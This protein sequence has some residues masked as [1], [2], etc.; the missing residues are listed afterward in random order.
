MS[1]MP[2]VTGGIVL[3]FSDRQSRGR[4][5]FNLVDLG[6]GPGK[7]RRGPCIWFRPAKT[8]GPPPWTSVPDPA[9][10]ERQRALPND[11]DTCPHCGACARHRNGTHPRGRPGAVACPA[12]AGQGPPRQHL[13]PA[14]R[15]DLPPA[16][17]DL[18][19][20]G[21]GPVLRGQRQSRGLSRILALFGCGVGTATLWRD[22]QAVAPSLVPD[23]EA[24]SNPW[25]WSWDPR[26]ND[27]TCAGWPR[28]RA[29]DSPRM[30]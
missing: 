26:G 29:P 18:P 8:T 7:G 13:A 27:W 14:A 23:P 4:H 6:C 16:A 2:R 3:R 30:A 19:G 1:A 5:C 9:H 17:A 10:P 21:G 25:P 20:T 24:K 22:V 28:L 12:L 15:R 11:P